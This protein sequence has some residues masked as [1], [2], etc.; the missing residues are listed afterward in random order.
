ML[1]VALQSMQLILDVAMQS[2]Q[3]ICWVLH[4]RGRLGDFD[5]SVDSVTR[6]STR[7]AATKLVYTAGFDAPELARYCVCV[8]VC[9]HT[10]AQA[11]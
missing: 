7:F 6:T 8:C 9:A 11:T 1:D 2:L 4:C 10:C 5:L 3:L